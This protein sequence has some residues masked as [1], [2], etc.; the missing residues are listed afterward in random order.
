M[1]LEN[2]NIHYS[3]EGK[4]NLIVLVNNT[5]SWKGVVTLGVIFRNFS[6]DSADVTWKTELFWKHAEGKPKVR[7]KPLD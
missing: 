7:G 3:R 1:V 6:G 2:K 5:E 4:I